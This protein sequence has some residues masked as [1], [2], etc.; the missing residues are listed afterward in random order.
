MEGIRAV[1]EKTDCYIVALREVDS[2]FL[3]P[4]DSVVVIMTDN[5]KYGY[6]FEVASK[7]A[8]AS[9]MKYAERIKIPEDME[10]R[11]NNILKIWQN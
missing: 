7:S 3:K 1:V 8:M 9:K 2:G 4:F 11:V 10:K 5:S 6:K